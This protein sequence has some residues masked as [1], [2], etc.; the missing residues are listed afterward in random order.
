[1]NIIITIGIKSLERALLFRGGNIT[2]TTLPIRLFLIR[3]SR[4]Y[5]TRP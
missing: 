5:I 4:D 1:M 3:T 2:V